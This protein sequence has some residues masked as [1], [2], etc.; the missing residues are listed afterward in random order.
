MLG[1]QVLDTLSDQGVGAK[2][3]GA[4]LGGVPSVARTHC[5]A[6]LSDLPALG[7]R[8]VSAIPA[9]KPYGESV[10]VAEH[11]ARS[12]GRELIR[13]AQEDK[14]GVARQRSQERVHEPEIDH[15]GFVDDHG[16]K[17]Q[18]IA[19][20]LQHPA[21]STPDA[22]QPVQGLRVRQV[23]EQRAVSLGGILECT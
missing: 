8:N 4:Q 21:W 18:G 11:G 7:L 22:E 23:R 12:D 1:R 16:A 10:K 17:G 14:Q 6:Q 5:R 9:F 20:P 3:K 19:C 15:R 2:A 13:V